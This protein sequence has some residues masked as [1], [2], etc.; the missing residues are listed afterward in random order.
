MLPFSL[1]SNNAG[2]ELQAGKTWIVILS[3]ADHFPSLDFLIHK[4]SGLD[5]SLVFKLGTLEL[6]GVPW[7]GFH[8][9]KNQSCSPF[10]SLTF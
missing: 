7:E 6:L 9:L 10:V 8:P 1:R 3:E 5:L 4:V 2:C